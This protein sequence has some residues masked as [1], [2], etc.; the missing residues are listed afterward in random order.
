MKK[1]FAK[2]HDEHKIT[3]SIHVECEDLGEAGCIVCQYSYEEDSVLF[4]EKRN[5]IVYE[6]DY[7]DYFEAR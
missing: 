5:K 7:C 1:K 3:P 4:C 2:K 6:S